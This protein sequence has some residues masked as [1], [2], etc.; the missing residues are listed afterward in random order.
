MVTSFVETIGKRGGGDPGK[1]SLVHVKCETLVTS[2]GMT[3][4]SWLRKP[5]SLGKVLAC[6]LGL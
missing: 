6:R 2:T 1:F 3:N 4:D 5:E